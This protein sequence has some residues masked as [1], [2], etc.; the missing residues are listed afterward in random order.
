MSASGGDWREEQ[1]E[2]RRRRKEEGERAR[3]K[4]RDSVLCMR[5]PLMTTPVKGR[6]PCELHAIIHT[7]IFALRANT[8]FTS[9]Y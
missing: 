8:G 4:D 5:Y 9:L 2:G 3:E 7:T 1:G 6:V